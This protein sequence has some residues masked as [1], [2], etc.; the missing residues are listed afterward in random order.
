[1][2]VSRTFGDAL[3]SRP[4]LTTSDVPVDDRQRMRSKPGTEERIE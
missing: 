2:V 3:R 4:P 1:M